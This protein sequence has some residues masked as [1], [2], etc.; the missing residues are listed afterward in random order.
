VKYGSAPKG[1]P[2]ITATAIQAQVTPRLAEDAV[3]QLREAERWLDSLDVVVMSAQSRIGAYT[4]QQALEYALSVSGRV[5]R[6]V[7]MAAA[8]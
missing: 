3:L 2:Q 6:V 4:P 7:Q 5:R 8:A 1:A